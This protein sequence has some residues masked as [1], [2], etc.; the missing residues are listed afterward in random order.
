MAKALKLGLT[1]FIISAISGIVLAV[2]YNVTA[3][4]IQGEHDRAVQEGL[5]EVVQNASRFELLDEDDVNTLHVLS[6]TYS[7]VKEIYFAYEGSDRVGMVISLS[8]SGYGGPV[9]MLIGVSSDGYISG[10]RIIEHTETPGLGA[11]VEDDS[12]TSQF[13]GIYNDSSLALEGQ[14]GDIVGITRATI[15]SKAVVE[16]AHMALDV[17]EIMFQM[18]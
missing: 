11:K 16:G 9:G 2:V 4:I 7:S 14:G 15:S 6:K 10:V 17:A 18:Y 3:P 12:F 1:L 8:V 13:V 5:C